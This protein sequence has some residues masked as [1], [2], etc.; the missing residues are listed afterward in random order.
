[1]RE[2][3]LRWRRNASGWLMQ[4]VVLELTYTTLTRGMVEYLVREV[5]ADKVL[6]G[7]DLPMRDPSPQLGW[8]TYAQ[9]PK[10]I[11]QKY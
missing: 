11:K 10:K 5:G 8:V 7:S 3:A 2:A 1:M 9:F 4:N 6:Y